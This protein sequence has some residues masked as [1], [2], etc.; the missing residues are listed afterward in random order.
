MVL[1]SSSCSSWICVKSK[2]RSIK[3]EE[4]HKKCWVGTNNNDPCGVIK[5]RGLTLPNLGEEFFLKSQYLRRW[6]QLKGPLSLSRCQQNH[7]SCPVVALTPRIYADAPG[8]SGRLLFAKFLGVILEDG[9]RVM[10]YSNLASGMMDVADPRGRSGTL[11]DACS[12]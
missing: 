11:G 5:A 6:P 9:M 1:L 7:E 10:V 4:E 12:S 2:A 8:H 3:A